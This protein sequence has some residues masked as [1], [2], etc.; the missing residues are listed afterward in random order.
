MTARHGEGEMGRVGDGLLITLSPCLPVTEKG[1]TML[2]P[3]ATL[4]I[5]CCAGLVEA[6]LVLA[7]PATGA[8]GLAWAAP[9]GF[10]LALAGSLAAVFAGMPRQAWVRRALCGA[11]AGMLAQACASAGTAAWS[12][13]PDLAAPPWLLAA[14]PLLGALGALLGGSVEHLEMGEHA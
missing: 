5:A 14:A 13:L 9:A 2:Q 11:A 3:T 12:G 8:P 4:I 10:C 7:A 1:G 6:L